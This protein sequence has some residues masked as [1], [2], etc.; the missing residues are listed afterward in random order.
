MAEMVTMVVS[1]ILARLLSPGEYGAI[2]IVTAFIAIANTFVVSGIPTALIQKKDADALDYS[3]VFFFNLGFSAFLYLIIFFGAGYVASFY[4]MDILRPVM[5]VMGLRLILAAVNSVQHSFVSKNMMFRKYFFSTLTGT[6]LA[7]VTGIIM[8]YTNFGVW[9]LVAQ[10]MIN[11]TVDTVFLWFTVRWRPKLAYSWSRVKSMLSYGWKILVEGLSNTV[12]SQLNNFII[13]KV[14]TS[15]DLALYNKGM[16]FPHAIVVNIST[17]ISSVLFPAMSIRQD[18]PD[19][20]KQLLRKSVRG[21][22]YLLFPMLVGLAVAGRPLFIVL[23]TEKWVGSVP[24]LYIFCFTNLLTIGMYPRH[25]ALKGIGRS[26][27]FMYEHILAR[28]VSLV[29]LVS[30]YRISVMAIATVGVVSGLVLTATVMYTSKRF[31]GYSYTEQIKDVIPT[32]VGCVLMG[33]PVYSIQ[34]LQLPALP[35]LIIQILSGAAIYIAYSYIAK[36]GEFFFF[37]SYF[38][39]IFFKGDIKGAQQ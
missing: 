1:I 17:A 11:T 33:V 34:L 30:V 36:I 31:N 14:Y 25:Q 10:Y 16:Q 28:V 4:N 8:A 18:N 5:R 38:K 15:A 29:L 9:A 2:A 3:S 35:T 37:L 32:L 21:S 7:G 13:G 12:F 39:G 27:I 26:D 20:V 19:R 22:S 23:L 24:F 6:V